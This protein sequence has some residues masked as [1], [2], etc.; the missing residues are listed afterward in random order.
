MDTRVWTVNTPSGGPL[1]NTVN[2]TYGRWRYAPDVNAFILAVDVDSSV[3]FYKLTAGSGLEK[4]V[5]GARSGISLS[6]FPNPFSREV[7]FRA[8]AA[9]IA[10]HD[11]SGRE[12]A[13]L[14]CASEVTWKPGAIPAGLYLVRA[15]SGGRSVVKTVFLQK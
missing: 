12:V 4:A 2:G 9:A 6:V 7:T 1:N 3:Y 15:Q 5:P 13:R 10:V 8:G 14:A 11:L